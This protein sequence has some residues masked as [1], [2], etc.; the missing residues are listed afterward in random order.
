[1]FYSTLHSPFKCEYGVAAT[2]LHSGV[3]RDRRQVMF[4]SKRFMVQ[5]VTCSM[6]GLDAITVKEYFKDDNILKR[7]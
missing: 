2:N 4:D 3:L 5:S 1:M 6:H 7:I